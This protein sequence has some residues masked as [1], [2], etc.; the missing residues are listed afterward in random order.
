MD[1][2]TKKLKKCS[3]DRTRPPYTIAYFKS[4]WQNKV[5]KPKDTKQLIK[6]LVNKMNKRYDGV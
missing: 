1:E 5:S 4:I 2:V 3:Q 6:G